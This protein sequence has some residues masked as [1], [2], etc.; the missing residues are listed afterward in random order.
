MALNPGFPPGQ[1]RIHVDQ[2]GIVHLDY[3][4]FRTP[5]AFGLTTAYSFSY[6]LYEDR[7][8][9]R[10]S[11][12]PAEVTITFRFAAQPGNASATTQLTGTTVT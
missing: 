1:V 9:G 8:D 10:V 11:S 4:I 5:T 7:E 2:S 3:Y 6:R 12:D